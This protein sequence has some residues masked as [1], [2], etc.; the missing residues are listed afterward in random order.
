MIRPD[1][2]WY[3]LRAYLENPKFF[4]GFLGICA[5]FVLFVNFSCVYPSVLLLLALITTRSLIGRRCPTCDRKLQQTTAHQN[6]NNR[7]ELQVIWQCPHD[8]YEEV[9]KIKG[10]SGLFGAS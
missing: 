8:G 4:L 7:F 10:D 1:H 9:E 5:V 6:K 2:R 3:D